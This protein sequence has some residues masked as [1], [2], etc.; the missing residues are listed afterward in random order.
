MI[1]AFKK[2]F[3]QAEIVERQFSKQ[4]FGCLLLLN[5]SFVSLS[6]ALSV[7]N[8]DGRRGVPGDSW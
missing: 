4:C 2:R 5:A 3:Y 7:I 8:N 6:K 1:G